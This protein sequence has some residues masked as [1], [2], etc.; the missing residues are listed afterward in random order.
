MSR[1]RL[2]K[3]AAP[4]SDSWGSGPTLGE[5][6]GRGPGGQRYVPAQWWGAILQVDPVPPV[7]LPPQALPKRRLVRQEEV[8]LLSA[9]TSQGGL[10]GG[11][12]GPS[13]KLT[14]PLEAPSC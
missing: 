9:T 3:L 7:Q 6:L 2:E 12:T 1:L 8:L 10:L 14:G 13:A 5:G 4:R 11:H